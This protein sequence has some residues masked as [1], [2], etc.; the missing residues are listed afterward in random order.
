[1][2]IP[3]DEGLTAAARGVVRAESRART[4]PRGLVVH[5]LIVL[6]VVSGVAA[7]SSG[8]SAAVSSA[9]GVGL[10]GANLWVMRRIMGAMTANGA[11]AAWAVVLPF[12]LLGLVAGAFALVRLG[13]AQPVPL[14]IGFALLPL[15]GV[16]LPRAS[17]VPGRVLPGDVIPFRSAPPGQPL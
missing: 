1:M 4:W 11:S 8:S 14:A 9:L 17:S 5:F 2:T 10:A 6:L 15:T 13:L 16:F 3:S 7:M 12:K